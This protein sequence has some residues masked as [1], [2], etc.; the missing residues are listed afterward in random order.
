MLTSGAQHWDNQYPGTLTYFAYMPYMPCSAHAHNHYGLN[1]SALLYLPPSWRSVPC[2]TPVWE[3]THQIVW[4]KDLPA[5]MR[6]VAAKDFAQTQGRDSELKWLRSDSIAKYCIK[7]WELCFQQLWIDL[8]YSL[9]T[10]IIK[11]FLYK[12]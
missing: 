5:L 6:Q 1:P 10:I 4:R 11:F 8:H 2:K 9:L 12:K 7:Y 3:T